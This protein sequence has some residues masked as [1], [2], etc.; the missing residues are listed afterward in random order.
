MITIDNLAKLVGTK[1]FKVL[2]GTTKLE[3]KYRG[4]VTWDVTTIDELEINGEV[5]DLSDFGLSSLDIPQGALVAF[6]EYETITS[7]TL[8]SGVIYLLKA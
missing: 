1:G 7:I 3:G 4:F 6:A 8:T 5:A 2:S